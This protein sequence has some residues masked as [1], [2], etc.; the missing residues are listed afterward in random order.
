M[1]ALRSRRMDQVAELAGMV[2]EHLSKL[3]ACSPLRPVRVGLDGRSAAGKTTSAD[4]LTSVAGA[5]GRHVMRAS[6]DDFH[7]PGHKARRYTVETC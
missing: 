4:R 5:C 3:A 7:P 1:A 6:I 2:V